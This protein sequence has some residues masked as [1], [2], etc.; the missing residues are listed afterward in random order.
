MKNIGVEDVEGEVM[1]FI[2]IWENLKAI[3]YRGFQFGSSKNLLRLINNF[4]II[5]QN[6]KTMAKGMN[7]QKATKK[8]PTKTPKEKKEEKR[9]KKKAGY[10]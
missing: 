10:E 9:E 7:S 3:F 2:A 5:T 8:A 6:P 1:E 4:P